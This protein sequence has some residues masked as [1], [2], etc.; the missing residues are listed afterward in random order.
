MPRG[1]GSPYGGAPRPAP[2]RGTNIVG[3]SVDP[4][5]ERPHQRALQGVG[6]ADPLP[7]TSVR[8]DPAQ[9]GRVLLC[10]CGAL[11]CRG[12]VRSVRTGTLGFEGAHLG[13]STEKDGAREVI[14]GSAAGN[15]RWLT[16]AWA[17]N[18][19]RA[20]G[21]VEEYRP[22]VERRSVTS[23]ALLVG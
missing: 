5:G 20:E 6:A 7:S 22:I 1:A 10:S 15:L 17:T 21:S 14:L 3:D 16:H 12:S 8:T 9:F 2:F 13:P 11:L 4:E 23:A 19:R 18:S